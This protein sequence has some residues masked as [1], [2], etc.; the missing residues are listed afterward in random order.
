MG[1]GV[2][3]ADLHGAEAANSPCIYLS[4]FVHSYSSHK[5]LA[6]VLSIKPNP[7]SEPQAPLSAPTSVPT[8][9]GLPEGPAIDGEGLVPLS[10]PQ[11]L[12][13]G[14]Y[15]FS[16]LFVLFC[17]GLGSALLSSLSEHVFYHLALPRIRRAKKLQYWLHTSQVRDLPHGQMD[18]GSRRGP[19]PN[20]AS[21]W[22]H[23]E[24]TVPSTLGHRRGRRRWSRS[25]GKSSGDQP[26]SHQLP[27][28]RIT[29]Q[30]SPGGQISSVPTALRLLRDT[31]PGGPQVGCSCPCLG[32]TL[33]Q[34]HP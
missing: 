15:H 1:V 33:A 31:D 6:H 9:P 14:I 17:L 7:A 21:V 11:T 29:P 26:P 18:A 5:T 16:G 4:A 8:R 12:Q 10:H 34:P 2:G 24:S 25:P 3:V 28:Q 20:T 32:G 23:R 19:D 30:P 22:A 27:C 13:V